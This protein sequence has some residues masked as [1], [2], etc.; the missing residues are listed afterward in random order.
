MKR[1]QLLNKTFSLL[2][3]FEDN[4]DQLIFVLSLMSVLFCIFLDL[5]CGADGK[6]ETKAEGRQY[7]KSGELI[8]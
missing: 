8:G 2:N 7:S 3:L 6:T 1:T 4:A 5:C